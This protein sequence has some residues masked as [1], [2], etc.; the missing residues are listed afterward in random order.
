MFEISER[1]HA[2]LQLMAT[3]ASSYEKE[4]RLSLKT[5]AEEAGISPTY[6]E[7]IA[8]ALRKAHLI[9]GRQGP[10]GGYRLT[11]PPAEITLEQIAT[12]LEGQVMLVECQKSPSIS[13]PQEKNCRTKNVWH[14]LQ[15]LVQTHLR[16]TSLSDILSSP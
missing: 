9:E 14:G 6:L 12:A 8:A 11:H 16:S 1:A 3:L 10:G 2:G 7:E 4:E 5:I 13:C 15:R